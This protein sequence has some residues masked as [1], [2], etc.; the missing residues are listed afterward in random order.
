[1]C[2]RKAFATSRHLIHCHHYPAKKE[3]KRLEKEAKLAAKA[4]KAAPTAPAGEKKTRE[5][6]AKEEVVPF[7]NTTPKGQKKGEFVRW[8]ICMA[9][10]DMVQCDGYRP[11]SSRHLPQR[12]RSWPIS[13]A[14]LIAFCRSVRTH[15]CWL[16]SNRY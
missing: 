15:G 7:V 5:K 13:R 12:L 14:T 2:V 8:D 11:S 4:A 6:A 9:L 1:V 10:S 3:A 16:R